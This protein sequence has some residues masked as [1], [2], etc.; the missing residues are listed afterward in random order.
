MFNKKRR[1]TK[2]PSPIKPNYDNYLIEKLNIDDLN[3]LPQDQETFRHLIRK[4]FEG[5]DDFREQYIRGNEKG[6]IFT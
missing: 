5:S 1:L 3:G 2:Q 6:G 4:A